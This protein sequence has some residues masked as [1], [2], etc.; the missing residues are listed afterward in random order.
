MHNRKAFDL[1]ELHILVAKLLNLGVKPSVVNW[2]IDFLRDRQQKVKVNG[3]F[4]D[5]LDVPA[6]VPQGTRLAPWLFLAMIND[7]CLLE[8]FLMW[9]FAD[10]ATVSEVVL[11]SKHSTLQQAADLIHDWSQENHLQLN[12]IKCKEIRT[13]FKRTSPCFSQV[14]MEGVEFEIVSLAKVLGVVISSELKWSARIDSTTTKA[15]KRLYLLRQ[16][17][18]ARIA[19]SDLV[20]FCCS[21]IRSILEYAG[22]IF[23][24]NLP[25][26]LSEEIEHIQ[27]RALPDIFS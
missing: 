20:S 19:Q 21:V 17:K 18:R 13:C 9:K 24:C 22:Q 15:A 6:G 7:L 2:I 23:H 3:V 10:D 1:V 5:W 25:L 16:P 14:A 27:H 11:P 8:G 12:P 26:Y 4:S